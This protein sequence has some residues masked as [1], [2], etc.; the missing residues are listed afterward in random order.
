[1]KS[2]VN[3][4]YPD[5]TNVV[6]E[7]ETIK[8]QFAVVLPHIYYKIYEGLFENIGVSLEI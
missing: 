4:T 5:I 3:F 8:A 7:S 2:K 6:R 1:M